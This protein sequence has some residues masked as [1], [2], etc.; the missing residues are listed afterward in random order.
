MNTSHKYRHPKRSVKP[1][2]L[3][4]ALALPGSAALAASTNDVVTTRADQSI[5]QQYGRG[6]IY[7]FS[8][9]AKPMKSEQA[10]SNVFGTMKTY[11]AEAW[12]KTEGFAV[13]AWD[14][15]TDFF[16][17]P[18]AVAQTEPQ[19]YGRAGGYVGADR[20]AVLES[21]NAS[22]ANAAPND[23]VKTGEGAMGA[24]SAGPAAT[25]EDT[26]VSAPLPQ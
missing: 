9:D 19:R 4:L 25:F 15:T 6:S 17:Q 7:A 1:V 13:A 14:K 12:H 3:A 11:A 8:P 21:H 24:F 23:T 22:Q 18:P 26:S 10:G 16:T 2:V 20:I 5:N